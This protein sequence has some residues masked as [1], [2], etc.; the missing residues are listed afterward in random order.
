MSARRPRKVKRQPA[1]TI[2]RLKALIIYSPEAGVFRWLITDRKR[3][4]GALAGT[5]TCLGY[6][7]IMIDYKAHRSNR[8]AYF[9]MTGNWPE[10]DID[11]DYIDHNKLNNRWNNLRPASKAQNS[12][13]RKVAS[14]SL[15]GIKGIFWGAHQKRWLAQVSRDGI[16]YRREFRTINHAKR[17]VRSKRIELHGEFAC[18]G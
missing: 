5:I 1:L 17:Y 9:Y 14:H 13:N 4:A 12:A 10:K 6:R 2:E 3:L 15:S 11:I 7:V 16:H 18:D 8:L